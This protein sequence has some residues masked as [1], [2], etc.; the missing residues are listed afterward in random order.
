VSDLVVVAFDDELEAF[1]V[2]DTMV[3]MQ[4]EQGEQRVS[5]EWIDQDPKAA[6]FVREKNHRKQIIPTIIFRDGSFLAEPNNS[7]H[8]ATARPRRILR[9]LFDFVQVRA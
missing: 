4:S 9:R 5:Y 3:R 2:R 8:S 6:E 1:A 7:N